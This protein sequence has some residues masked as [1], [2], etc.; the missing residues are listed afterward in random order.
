MPRTGWMLTMSAYHPSSQLPGPAG[1]WF[2]E[3]LKARWQQHAATG[4]P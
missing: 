2:I 3:Q 1:Q 4:A